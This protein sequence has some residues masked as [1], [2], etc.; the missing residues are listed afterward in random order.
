[1]SGLVVE[2]NDLADGLSRNDIACTANIDLDLVESVE[3]E[4]AG[5]VRDFTYVALVEGVCVDRY[6]KS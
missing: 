5:Y 6:T 1:M 2:G 4:P 3:R